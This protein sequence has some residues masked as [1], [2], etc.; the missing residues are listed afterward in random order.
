[1]EHTRYYDYP[2]LGVIRNQSEFSRLFRDSVNLRM[3]SDV[4]VG[5]SLSGGLD[6]SAIAD[7]ARTSGAS[8]HAYTSWFQPFRIRIKQ[9]AM[10]AQNLITNIGGR[11]TV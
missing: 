2:P 11:A 10:V 3:R 6:S 5:I 1:M 8:L 9:A 7:T 4:P